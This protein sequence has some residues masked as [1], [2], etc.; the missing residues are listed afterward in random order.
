MKQVVL[1]VPVVLA[2]LASPL[3]AQPPQ[4]N[5]LPLVEQAVKKAQAG[6]LQ[7]AIA[8]LE[9]LKS[10][11]GVHPGT[12]ST[13]GSLYLEAGRAKDA[14]EVL[15]PIAET[16]AAGPL[17]LQN[18]ARAALALGQTDKAEAW[19]RRVVAKAPGSP[20]AREL[21]ILLG[22]QARIAESYSLLRP[23]ALAHPDD[24]EARLSAAFGAIELDRSPEAEEL[25]K[26]LPEDDPRARLLRG[27][28]QLL[29][30][31]PRAAIA[32]LEPLLHGAPPNLES[33]ARRAMAD[34]HIA[35]GQSGEAISLLEGKVGQD[36]SLALLLAKAHFKSGDPAQAAA[37][38]EPFALNLLARDPA[39]S[40]ERI[41]AS[42]VGLEYGQALVALSKW[43]EAVT[44]LEK[45]T[46]LAPQ[47]LQAW[48]LLGRAQLAAGR[49]E[50]ATRS[51]E[52]F[53]ELQSAQKEVMAQMEDVDKGVA[54]PT[55]RNLQRAA[56]LAAGGRTEDALAMI[57]QEIGFVP[58]D[59]RPRIAEVKTLLEAKRTAEALKAAEAG[60][61]AFPGNAELVRLRDSARAATPR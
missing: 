11:P 24:Q 27:R 29:K 35:L 26:G 49:R 54:D 8:L 56:D 17:I 28:L 15:G 12:L 25:L 6:D 57:R 33:G 18:A 16:E 41:L 53:R 59:P 48:Q 2:V 20:A 45:V 32:T 50:D 40:S 22:S 23:W 10:L 13:L 37:V 4:R 34:A 21:G 19:L 61:A 14:L 30:R 36:P 5:D 7:G 52:R 60:L 3:A 51:M 39:A 43:P 9:P 42:D 44:V 47:S 46:R 1:A 55:G 31:D 58:N 38:L